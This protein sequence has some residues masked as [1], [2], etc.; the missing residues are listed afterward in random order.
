MKISNKEY[1][2]AIIAI[3]KQKKQYSVSFDP[4]TFDS[5]LTKNELP[6]CV[7]FD[8]MVDTITVPRLCPKRYRSSVENNVRDLGHKLS[9]RRMNFG[10]VIS[11][12]RE[13]CLFYDIFF[14]NDNEDWEQLFYYVYDELRTDDDEEADIWM[15]MFIISKRRKTVDTSIAQA[16]NI[17]IACVEEFV[18]EFGNG[19]EIEMNTPVRIDKLNLDVD[20]YLPMVVTGKK[21]KRLSQGDLVFIYSYQDGKREMNDSS[22]LGDMSLTDIQCILYAIET[23]TIV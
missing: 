11:V 9:R 20:E 14:D 17:L 22:L 21:I 23:Q 8:A 1:F 13:G 2:D 6:W 15:D 7:R 16:K 18:K 19:R 5:A 3:L 4:C 10:I 12:D